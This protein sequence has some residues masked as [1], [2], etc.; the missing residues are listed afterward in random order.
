MYSLFEYVLVTIYKQY[1]WFVHVI[2][3][4]YF[5]DGG[6]RFDDKF[7]LYEGCGSALI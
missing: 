5:F 1:E 3:L 7:S 2:W 4:P 6:T